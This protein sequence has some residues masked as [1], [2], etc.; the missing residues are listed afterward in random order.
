MAINNNLNVLNDGGGSYYKVSASHKYS[1]ISVTS[2]KQ[3]V[4]D[5]LTNLKSAEKKLNGVTDSFE[6]NIHTVDAEIRSLLYSK[7]GNLTYYKTNLDGNT[8]NIKGLLNDL[9]NVCSYI[10]EINEIET[11][12][13]NNPSYKDTGE[14]LI[15][16]YED[17][18]DDLIPS[19]Y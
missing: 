4:S 3:N 5:A 15:K 2:L 13:K 18:I 9:S 11:K 19:T 8:Y 6:S 12:I 10:E 7:L 17:K 14:R 16:E 1:G